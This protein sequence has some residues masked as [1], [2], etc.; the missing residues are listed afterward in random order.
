MRLRLGSLFSGWGGLDMAI[1][2]AFASIGV[3]VELAWVSDIEQ[4]DKKGHQIGDD[5]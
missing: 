5:Q 1:E 2:A 3:E 4:F